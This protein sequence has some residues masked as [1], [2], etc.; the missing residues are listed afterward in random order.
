MPKS[1]TAGLS[2]SRSGESTARALR[3][4]EWRASKTRIRALL[5]YE[6]VFFEAFFAFFFRFV[7][8]AILV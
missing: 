6:E 5:T 2:S 8:A 3:E 1:R 7:M 4:F